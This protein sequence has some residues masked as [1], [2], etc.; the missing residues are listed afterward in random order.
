M[1]VTPFFSC[2]ENRADSTVRWPYFFD[3][4]DYEAMQNESAAPVFTC[5]NGIV[6]FKAD[7]VLPIHLRSNTSLSTDPLPFKLPDTHPAAND[8]SLRGLSPALTPPVGFRASAPDECYSSECFLLP[9]DFRRMFNLQR[10]FVNPRVIVGYEWR[11]VRISL[12]PIP[13]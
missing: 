4:E 8:S 13:S 5:W 12:S 11:Y 2:E 9:Y 10:I 3:Q 6:V 1:Y 7:P